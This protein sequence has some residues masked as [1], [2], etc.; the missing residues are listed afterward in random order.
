MTLLNGHLSP[1]DSVTDLNL[2]VHGMQNLRVIDCSICPQVPSANTNAVAVMIGERG[3]DFIL[4]VQKQP[5][6]LKQS[7]PVLA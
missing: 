3:A 7:E 4:S 5:I 6:K 1:E 2:K